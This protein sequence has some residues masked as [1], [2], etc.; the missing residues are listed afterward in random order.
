MEDQGEPTYQS[1]LLL[2]PVDKNP[3]NFRVILIGKDSNVGKTITISIIPSEFHPFTSE[4]EELALEAYTPLLPDPEKGWTCVQFRTESID[5]QKVHKADVMV[6]KN[7]TWDAGT[8]SI[9]PP[10]CRTADTVDLS[11]LLA[12]LVANA[13]PGVLN[14]I[15]TGKLRPT[16]ELVISI[17]H[18]FFST[19]Q[20]LSYV[21][22]WDAFKA[23]DRKVEK[24]RS[25]R[26]QL[27]GALT[28]STS[29][30]KPPPSVE[31]IKQILNSEVKGDKRLN[32]ANILLEPLLLHPMDFVRL[33][34]NPDVAGD[35]ASWLFRRTF[36]R[37]FVRITEYFIP[38]V[39]YPKHTLIRVERDPT[40]NK[41]P[42]TV[43]L[44]WEHSPA[45]IEQLQELWNIGK[46]QLQ[47][48]FSPR[49]T[50]LQWTHLDVW[51][52]NG[53]LFP[54]MEEVLSDLFRGRTQPM[55]L[56]Y[57][58]K[59]RSLVRSQSAFSI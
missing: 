44:A 21:Q 15:P 51:V 31:L 13:N 20:R 48:V 3:M 46:K 8:F 50:L 53:I 28:Q 4:L 33:L 7:P 14:K 18:K 37:T 12:L 47:K 30:G 32:E 38:V 26:A 45:E 42:I 52:K 36:N 43:T 27:L 11:N 57:D 54:F 9:R 59:T 58:E 1:G 24:L 35:V 29:M 41:I 40:A 10:G 25:R 16:M 6:M 39:Q 23:W 49:L 17:V 55:R 22:F 19:F 2:G 56:D 34:D 5:A